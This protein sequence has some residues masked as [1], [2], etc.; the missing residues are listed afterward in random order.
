MEYLI[1]C[2]ESSKRGELFSNFY[3]GALV[4]SI[5]LNEVILKLNNYK[6]EHGITGEM[7]WTKV[8]EPYLEKYKGLM[9][10]FFDLLAEDKIKMRVMFQQNSV[11]D[12]VIRNFSKEEHGESYFK[13][14]YQFIKHSF[15]L[16]Y[17]NLTSN[18]IYVRLFFDQF[19]DKE[20]KIDKFKQFIHRLQ[21]SQDFV[22]ANL[23]IRYDDIVEVTSH[24]HI[25]LQCAD[26]VTGAIFF[27]LNKLNLVTDSQ[28]RRRGKRTI[29]KEKLYKHI[30]SRISEMRPRFNIGVSTGID[31]NISN[32]WLNPYMHW[33]FTP[34][35]VAVGN[36]R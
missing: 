27:K 10:V 17:S 6:K 22:N 19:P 21:Y 4:K 25:I 30:Y 12:S 36:L 1:Y 29:A 35:E 26:I 32:R 34:A 8:T 23:S 16:K 31:G 9:D 2:D 28:T 33:L 15:G 11:S 24:D 14:Y 5:H 20:E 18:E 3:G 13:L 7:K